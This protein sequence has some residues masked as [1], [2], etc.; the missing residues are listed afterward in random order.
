MEDLVQLLKGDF[1][2]VPQPDESFDAIY[3]IEAT[4]HAP[5]KEGVY[6]ELY[7]LLKPGGCFGGYEW[8]MTDKYDPKNETHKKIKYGIE[9][10]NSLPEIASTKEVA[11]ALRK[12]GFEIIELTDFGSIDTQVRY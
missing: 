1:M 12:V 11:D 5:S 6:A 9:I 7:R 8:C 4:P 10:G 3:E 2:H